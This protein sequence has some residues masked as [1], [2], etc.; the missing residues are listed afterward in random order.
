M[1]NLIL[2]L[3]ILTSICESSIL[4]AQK[5]PTEQMGSV[6]LP[7]EFKIDGLANEWNDKF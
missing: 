5:L 7:P 4:K 6:T 2:S 3:L 1:K